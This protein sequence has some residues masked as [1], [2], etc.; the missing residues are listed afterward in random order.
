M[1]GLGD[2]PMHEEEEERAPTGAGNHRPTGLGQGRAGGQRVP[3]SDEEAVRGVVG[4]QAM[5]HGNPYMRQ[6]P[7][8][9]RGQAMEE[10]EESDFIDIVDHDDGDTMT[11]A[12]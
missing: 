1:G 6:R 5:P 10:E 8:Q 4:R 7:G 11:Q 2:Y 9:Q 12:R 3:S